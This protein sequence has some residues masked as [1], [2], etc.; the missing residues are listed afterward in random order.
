M[1]F[2]D[3]KTFSAPW[4]TVVSYRKLP[5]GTEVRE[6]ICLDRISTT[7]AIDEKKYLS[8]PK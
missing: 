8:Y 2:E 7:P 5:S 3:A 1:R 4:D 6:D